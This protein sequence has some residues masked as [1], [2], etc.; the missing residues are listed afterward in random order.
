MHEYSI[1]SSMLDICEKYAKDRE[2]DRVAVKIGK[3]SGIE[4]HFLKSSFDIFKEDTLCKDATL[5]MDIIDI[6]LKCIDCNKEAVVD[7]FNFFCP[8]CKEG[9]T[10]VLTGQE[11]YIDY[12]ELKE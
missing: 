3:M 6:T 7:S 1:V 12:I 8:Y 5:Q 4:P 10:E 9:N 11:M 2:V